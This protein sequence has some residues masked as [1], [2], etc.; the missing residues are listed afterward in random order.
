MHSLDF[1]HSISPEEA[2][3]DPAALSRL[4]QLFH[5]QI[6]GGLHPAAQMVVIKDGQVLFD[7]AVGQFNGGMPVRANTPFYCF[8]VSK[9]FT[10]MCVHKL[11]EEGK[12]ALDA[13]IAEYW[14]AF[15]KNG[16]DKIT[17]RQVFHHTAGVSAI[18]RYRQIPLWPF[19][20]LATADVA[21]LTPEYPPGSKMA[22]H[23]VSWGFIFGEV[24][25][26]VSGLR[27]EIYFDQT[28]AQPLGM[29]NSWFRTPAKELKRSPRIL[30]GHP[31]QERLARV[32]NA[33]PI[34]RSVIPAGSL[35]STARELAI[36]YQMLVNL[37]EY[38]GK[39]YLK[40][41]TVE[42]AV[43]LGY[44]GWDE[45]NKRDTL[46]AYGFH[47]GGRKKVES[48]REEESVYGERSTQA[49]FGHMGNRSCMAWGDMNHRLVVT[50]TCNRLIGYRE[51]RQ[52]WIELNNAVWD[53]IGV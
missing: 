46:W 22:Y 14:P 48:Q 3:V 41:E 39:R 49:T 1:S 28:F 16:K 24:I 43:S 45:I 35:T 2:G 4:D 15:G 23:A 18:D 12:V 52:R 13:P 47:L 40:P 6:T 8:S 21:N 26:R 38:G 20:P 27:F 25:R 51:T 19:W 31:D 17:I 44:R 7:Q 42:Q 10:G 5:A 53:L 50:F 32:F 37:G 36:F 11:I 30:V 34:R 29:T 9:A 33:L